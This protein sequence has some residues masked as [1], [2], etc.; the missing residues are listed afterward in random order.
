MM[1]LDVK[2]IKRAQDEISYEKQIEQLTQAFVKD[3]P[4]S[5]MVK[6]EVDSKIENVSAELNS[7]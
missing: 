4:W 1:L 2:D 7:V 6:K 3:T 5:D